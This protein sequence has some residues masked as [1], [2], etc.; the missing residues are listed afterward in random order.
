MTINGAETTKKKLGW[1]PFQELQNEPDALSA[2]KCGGFVS[3]YLALIYLV[4]IAIVCMTDRDHPFGDEDIFSFIADIFGVMLAIFLTW[5]IVAAQSLWAI[6]LTSVWF[7]T[8][9]LIKIV[10]IANV[11]QRTSG[12]WVVTFL[13][14]LGGTILAIR[15]GWKLRVLSRRSSTS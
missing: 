4:Q 15:G 13:A 14:L 2:A 5:R 12:W 8:E 1:N 11:E 9:I 3:G 6:I 7:F 10:A